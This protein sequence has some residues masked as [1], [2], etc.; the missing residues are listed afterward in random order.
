LTVKQFV[1]APAFGQ[2]QVDVAAA[3]AGGAGRDVDEVAAQ[4]A[5]AGLARAPAADA[6]QQT[7]GGA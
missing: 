6:G 4:C 7:A 5:A 3:V 1:L 2:V